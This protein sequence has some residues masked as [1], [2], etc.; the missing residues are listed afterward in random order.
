LLEAGE[1]QPFRFLHLDG[2]SGVDPETV[3]PFQFDRA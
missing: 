1:G 3:P 2:G